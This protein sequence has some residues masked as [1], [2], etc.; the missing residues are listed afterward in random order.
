MVLRAEDPH[1]NGSGSGN[2]GNRRKNLKELQ[3]ASNKLLLK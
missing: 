3:R 2:R 1:L